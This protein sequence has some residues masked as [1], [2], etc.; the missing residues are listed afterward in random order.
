MQYSALI[1]WTRAINR[2]IAVRL[3]PR[4]I[5]SIWNFVE[6]M[7]ECKA[8]RS[9]PK[10]QATSLVHSCRIMG[11]PET[12]SLASAPATKV[13]LT[14]AMH[15]RWRIRAA[16]TIRGGPAVLAM[17][18]IE[19]MSMNTFGTTTGPECAAAAKDAPAHA[20]IDKKCKPPT[21]L[22]FRRCFAGVTEP[23]LT[24]GMFF[25]VR[26]LLMTTYLRREIII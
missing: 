14:V 24:D 18:L 15:P 16:P 2:L 21:A 11:T 8:L 4:P 10:F 22:I 3:H 7:D 9:H 12:N 17:P 1:S 19:P 6:K 26:E 5:Q 25:H 13:T 20:R 23:R